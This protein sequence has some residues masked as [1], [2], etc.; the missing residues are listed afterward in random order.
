[1]IEFDFA[2]YIPVFIFIC[3]L[4]FL[5]NRTLGRFIDKITR[6]R[7]AIQSEAEKHMDAY[8]KELGR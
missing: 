1:M 6:R 2:G 4:V 5:L 7:E 3:V 8:L